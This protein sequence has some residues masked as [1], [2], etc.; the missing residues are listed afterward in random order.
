MGTTLAGHTVINDIRDALMGVAP[1]YIPDSLDHAIGRSLLFLVLMH[2]K[3]NKF[4]DDAIMVMRNGASLCLAGPDANTAAR[5]VTVASLS[6]EIPD[7]VELEDVSSAETYSSLV[8]AFA[9]KIRSRG[10]QVINATHELDATDDAETTTVPAQPVHKRRRPRLPSW[11]IAAIA[12]VVVL[13]IALSFGVR[14]RFH[15]FALSPTIHATAGRIHVTGQPRDLPHVQVF[16]NN[17]TDG[18]N[19][20]VFGVKPGPEITGRAISDALAPS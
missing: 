6:D 10:G 1:A 12:A 11:Q 13:A 9:Q 8:E 7:E 5:I 2:G 14:S 18:R 17:G 19:L 20:S 3:H 15:A 16:G 4:I